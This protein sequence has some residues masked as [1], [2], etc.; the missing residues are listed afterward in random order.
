MLTCAE[1][2]NPHSRYLT[3]N[4]HPST[5]LHVRHALPGPAVIVAANRPSLCKRGSQ[6][7]VVHAGEHTLFDDDAPR[8][9]HVVR[10]AKLK[11]L[12]ANAGFTGGGF[13]GNRANL[14]FH[15]IHLDCFPCHSLLLAQRPFLFG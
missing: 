6:R 15:S 12:F 3:I 13:T 11:D 7:R 5:L 9:S 14:P 4:T 8:R 2:R 1:S 10:G